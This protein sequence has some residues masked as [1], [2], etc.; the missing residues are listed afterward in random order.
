MPD[1]NQPSNQGFPISDSGNPSNTQPNSD[2]LLQFESLL[3]DLRQET[4]PEQSF[5]QPKVPAIAKATDSPSNQSSGSE[6]SDIVIRKIEQT[7]YGLD[8]IE[9]QL[10]SLENSTGAVSHSPMLTENLL[11]ESVLE[12]SRDAIAVLDSTRVCIATRLPK[13]CLVLTE[14]N[15]LA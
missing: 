14:S 12:C 7:L 6:T 11:A 5:H 3:E 10:G 9:F 8:E 1:T 13:R 2:S 15:T 4:P